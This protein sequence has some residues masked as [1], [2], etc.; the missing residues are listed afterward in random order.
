MKMTELKPGEKA[1]ITAVNAQGEI[2]QR[3]VDMGLVK[4]TTFKVLRKAPLGD[5]I[6]IQMRG[7]LLA[8][9][10]KEAECVGVERS[11]G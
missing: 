1:V 5:P 6:E 9:R 10:L 7:F 8:L 2:A 3:L 4:G 11:G